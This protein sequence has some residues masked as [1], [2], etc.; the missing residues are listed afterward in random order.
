MQITLLRGGLL[1]GYILAAAFLIVFFSA[2]GDGSY[3]PGAVLLG[4]GIV[5][6]QLRIVPGAVGFLLVPAVHLL[7]FFAAVSLFARS[8]LPAG[9]HAVGIV[10]AVLNVKHGHL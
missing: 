4:W 5:P 10:I 7:C 3:A 8:L 2:A 9:I 1:A 6:W